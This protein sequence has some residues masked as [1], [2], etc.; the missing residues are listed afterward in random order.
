MKNSKL[1]PFLVLILSLFITSCSN[2]D[3]ILTEAPLESKNL[4]KSFKIEKDVN[5][6]YSVDVNIDKNTSVE[7]VR[8]SITKSNEFHFLPTTS[9]QQQKTSFESE[10]WFEN[11]NLKLEFLNEGSAPKLVTILDDNVKFSERGNETLLKNY[12][13]TRNDDGTYDLDFKLK[14]EVSAAFTFDE[15]NEI[16]EIHLEKS[17]SKT[18]K[19]FAR[20]FEK[21]AGKSLEIHFVNHYGDNAKGAYAPDRK[22][23]IIIDEG[24]DPDGY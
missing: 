22:P 6:Y 15:E 20:T 10:L 17:D 9:E 4:N 5:G 1:F 23:V 12:S 19:E 14:D 16:Y 8:N 24:E 7:Q 13:I 21:E 11:D 2:E 18:Q 3:S